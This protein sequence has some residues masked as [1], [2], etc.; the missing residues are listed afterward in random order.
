MATTTCLDCKV[1]P[2][3]S[4]VFCPLHAAA[5]RMRDFVQDMATYLDTLKALGAVDG[6]NVDERRKAARVL[7]R[8]TRPV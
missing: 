5:E 3:F 2:P 6:P 1:L 4:I 8:D 7:L